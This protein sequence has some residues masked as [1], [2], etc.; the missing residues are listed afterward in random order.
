MDKKTNKEEE[1]KEKEAELKLMKI[2]EGLKK[3]KENLEKEEKWKKQ[4]YWTAG[5]YFV[6]PIIVFVII[7]IFSGYAVFMKVWFQI[8]FPI[9]AGFWGLTMRAIEFRK[10]PSSPFPEYITLYPLAIFM[11]GFVIFTFLFLVKFTCSLRFFPAALA[12]GMFMG[13]HSH[14]GSWIFGVILD[15]FKPRV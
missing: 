9:L 14:P 2:E 8:L 1:L 15:K 12:L 3:K 10:Y 4:R 11:N 13:F 6:L 7:L 5:F